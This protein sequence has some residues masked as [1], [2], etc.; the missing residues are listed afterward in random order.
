MTRKSSDT[1]NASKRRDDKHF[2]EFQ[3][4][5]YD[6]ATEP[7]KVILV[8]VD[9][10]FNQAMFTKSS[11]DRRHLTGGLGFERIPEL[12]VA[13]A[14]DVELTLDQRYKEV[15]VITVK[16]I[17]SAIR[18]VI[19]LNRTRDLLQIPYLVRGVVDGRDKLNVT[20]VGVPEHRREVGQAVD[21]FLKRRILQCSAA[22]PMYHLTVVFK[23]ETS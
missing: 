22:V 10:F 19:G 23:N 15:E 6:S 5:S 9:H 14:A 21:G 13:K 17:K 8:I 4:H 20:A 3:G 16:E 11:D 2:A 12:T 18:A 7:C 1:D